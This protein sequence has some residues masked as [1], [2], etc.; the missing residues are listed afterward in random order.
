VQLPRVVPELRQVPA[1]KPQRELVLERQLVQVPVL[2]Q[3]QARV[4][5]LVQVPLLVQQA[6]CDRCSRVHLLV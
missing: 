5:Q 6:H 1:Q 2:E 4:P 3:E